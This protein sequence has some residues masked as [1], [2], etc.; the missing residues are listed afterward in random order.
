M[1]ENKVNK[2]L[3]GGPRSKFRNVVTALL[4]LAIVVGIGLLIP[5]A[6]E[7]CETKF[8]E[9]LVSVNPNAPKYWR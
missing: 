7:K 2:R 1:A 6:Y 9:M 8:S 5:F 3:D 4:K